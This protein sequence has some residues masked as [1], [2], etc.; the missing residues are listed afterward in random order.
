VLGRNRLKIGVFG[1]NWIGLAMVDVPESLTPTWEA[2]RA[3]GQLAD[4]VGFE[5]IVSVSRWKSVVAGKPGHRSAQILEPFIWATAMALSTERAAVFVTCHVTAFP[6]VLAAKQA[7]TIDQISGG[8]FGLNV[9]A[10]WNAR[11]PHMFGSRMLPHEERYGKAS[12]WMEVVRRVWTSEEE[13]DHHGTYYD[14]DGAYTEPK[15]AQAPTPVVMNAGGSEWGMDF[16]ARYSDLAFVALHDTDPAHAREMVDTYRAHARERYGREI[17]VWT[18]AYIVQGDTDEQARAREEE[19]YAAGDYEYA[20]AFIAGTIETGSGLPLEVMRVIRRRMVL[21]GGAVPMI[22]S[23]ESI[24][25]QLEAL[26]D[27]GIDGILLNWVDYLGGIQ[28]FADE[29]LPLLEARGLREPAQ[30]A[31]ATARVA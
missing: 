26:S 16:A 14:L 7:A 25:D 24:A 11:E 19:L 15:P 3:I 4:R 22:G 20:D 12:E 30:R 9:V 23:A 18:N 10:G 17:N 13:F 8:R 21:G 29:V 2:S 28:R 27:A 31:A 5:A 6:P 1:I